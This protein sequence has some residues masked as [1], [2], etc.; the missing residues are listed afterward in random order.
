M[1]NPQTMNIM[2]H[3]DIHID[4]PLPFRVGKSQLFTQGEKRFVGFYFEIDIYNKN[5]IQ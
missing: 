4:L 5:W 3:G 2:P 1:E